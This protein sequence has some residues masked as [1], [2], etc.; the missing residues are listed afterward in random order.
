MKADDDE[1]EE[2]S[3]S[4]DLASPNMSGTTIAALAPPLSNDESNEGI[5][6]FMANSG[7]NEL[8]D[9]FSAL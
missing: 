4:D 2:E 6:R 8:A 7:G 3:G 9:S 5:T 1:E